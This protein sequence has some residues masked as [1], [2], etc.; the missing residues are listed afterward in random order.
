MILYHYKP[1][2]GLML[3]YHADHGLAIY[4]QSSS[5]GAAITSPSLLRGMR[6]KSEIARDNNWERLE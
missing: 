4:F 1:L 3:G 6:T 5:E 2:V